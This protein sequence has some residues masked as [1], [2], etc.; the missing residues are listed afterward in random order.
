MIVCV[1]VCPLSDSC[2]VPSLKLALVFLSVPWQ[3]NLPAH[4]VIVKGTSQYS[5]GGTSELSTAQI[6]Q[7]I[8]RAGRPQFDTSAVAVVLTTMTQKLHYDTALKGMKPIESR[9]R[10]PCNTL[11]CLFCA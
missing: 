11:A 1:C 7:M 5:P 9:F 4:V 3:V 6:L 2:L 10:E 8:G